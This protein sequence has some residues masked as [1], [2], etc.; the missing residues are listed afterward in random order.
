TPAPQ[1]I[2]LHFGNGC[3]PKEEPD[4]VKRWLIVPAN[5]KTVSD[6]HRY[7]QAHIKSLGKERRLVLS[8]SRFALPPSE[9][10]AV[11]RDG[12]MVHVE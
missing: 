12:D 10:L 9:A 3:V 2:R 6:L 5:L 1:R 7:L 4:L 11:V 8:V